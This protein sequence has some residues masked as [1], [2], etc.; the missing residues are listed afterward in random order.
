MTTQ[1]Q[2]ASLHAA[3]QRIEDLAELIK[4]ALANDDPADAEINLTELAQ[5]AAAVS[6]KL[7]GLESEDEPP[8]A[9]ST[10]TS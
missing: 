4:Q 3:V 7:A 6:E 5:T 1:Q 10:E 2:I 8:V 9:D